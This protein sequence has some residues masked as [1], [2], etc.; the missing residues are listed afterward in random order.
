MMKSTLVTCLLVSVC[1][2]GLTLA[3]VT[4]DYAALHKQLQEGLITLDEYTNMYTQCI[5]SQNYPSKY[6]FQPTCAYDTPVTKALV[7]FDN[8]GMFTAADGTE[9]PFRVRGVVTLT[10]I[11]NENTRVHATITGAHNFLFDNDQ[12]SLHVHQKGEINPS[13][14]AT[15]GHYNP[16][17][18]SHSNDPSV[19]ERHVGDVARVTIPSHVTSDQD[20]LT[21]STIDTQVKLTGPLSVLGRSITVHAGTGSPRVG[22]GTIAVSDWEGLD[23]PDSTYDPTNP[24]WA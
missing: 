5:S 2:I 17:G 11:D 7:K 16:C 9:H 24:F 8:S 20:V 22:C 18:L 23:H 19:K 12:F 13:C 1:S 3:R 10:Q 14:L 21:I 15:G 6:G 4:C